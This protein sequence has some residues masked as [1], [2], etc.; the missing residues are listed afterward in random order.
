MTDRT[1]AP[2]RNVGQGKLT[3]RLVIV[4]G[5]TGRRYDLGVAPVGWRKHLWPRLWWYR[6][7]QLPA[8]KRHARKGL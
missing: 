5:D 1:V 8:R 4:A 7:V 6:A 3:Q 2:V